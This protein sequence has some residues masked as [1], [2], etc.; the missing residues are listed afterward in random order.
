MTG[1][2]GHI[3]G[4]LLDPGQPVILNPSL[5]EDKVI[6]LMA[7]Q[8]DRT[9]GVGLEESGLAVNAQVQFATDIGV[10][11]QT[12]TR[13][14]TIVLETFKLCLHCEIG[15]SEL[16]GVLRGCR[17]RRNEN[18]GAVPDGRPGEK[19]RDT[20]ELDLVTETLVH[21]RPHAAER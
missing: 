19:N 4:G 6:E 20:N 2:A 8:T 7:G 14:A 12:P 18:R 1:H 15:G 16:R 17:L 21:D 11:V 3:M 10:T 9:R 5:I 13:Y